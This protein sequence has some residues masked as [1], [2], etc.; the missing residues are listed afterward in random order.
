[1]IAEQVNYLTTF[2][3]KSILKVQT[4][5]VGVFVLF[6]IIKKIF[7]YLLLLVLLGVFYWYF[8]R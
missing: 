4:K 1:M 7:K 2:Y 3:I 5:S 8:V 6:K